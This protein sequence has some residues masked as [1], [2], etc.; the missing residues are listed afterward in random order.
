MIVI[1][2]TGS[3]GMGKTTTA[4]LFAGE[5]VPVLDSDEVVHG[6]YRAEA[7]SLIEAA[8]PGTTVSGAVDRQ[9]LGE[10]LRKN[11]AN[12]SKLEEIV[13]PLVRGRQEDFLAQARKEDRQF[14]LLDIPLLFETGA[15]SRVDKVVVVSCAPEIQRERVL[16]RPGM[17]EEKFEMILS[18]QLP[19]P[20]KRRRADFIVDSGKGVEAA[21]DQVKEI[22]QKLAAESRRGDMNA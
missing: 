16:S 19:D 1:G 12:F 18:R 3:I 4:K 9:K 11:P 6:L 8:F 5:G 21:R 14:A 2:L 20:E 13:H 15:E 7:V 10:V 17:T 22:L